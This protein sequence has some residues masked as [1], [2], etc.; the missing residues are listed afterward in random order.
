MGVTLPGHF[1]GRN[2]RWRALWRQTTL[3]IGR[4]HEPLGA[5]IVKRE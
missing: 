3:K 1:V 5:E 2:T 4:L